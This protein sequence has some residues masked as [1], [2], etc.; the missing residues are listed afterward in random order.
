MNEYKT[1]ASCG[2]D[3]CI[4][5]KT[6]ISCNAEFPDGEVI[7]PVFNDPELD[8]LLHW[9]SKTDK[10]ETEGMTME[11]RIIA[12]LMKRIEQL[13]TDVVSLRREILPL[14]NY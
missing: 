5:N 7:V 12:F 9:A 1:C 13:E 11:Q 2:S 4:N 10:G 6:C 14:G 3:N 8:I